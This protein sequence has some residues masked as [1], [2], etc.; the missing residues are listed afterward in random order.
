MLEEVKKAFYIAKKDLR[1]YYFK[2][3]TISWGIVFPFVF[4]FA[5]LIRSTNKAWI[6]PGLLALS[7]L[8]SSTSM[9]SASVVFERRIG[10]F[11]RLLLF[12]IS[13]T[14]IAF[15]K[16]LS[17]FFFGVLSSILTVLAIFLF[18]GSLPSNPFFLFLTLI[19][20]AFQFSSLGVFLSFIAKDPPQ[21]MVFVNIVRFLMMFMCGIFVPLSSLPTFI[22]P[23]SLA[24]P[25][26]YSVEAIRF[27]MTG[28][29]E[30]IPPY[31]SF[32]I[33]LLSFPLFLYTTTFLI[34][35]SLE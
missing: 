2:P 12:P 29:Y 5:F 18:L 25:L 3:P 31:I 21:S 6:S 13:Y 1:Q 26:T 14:G 30:V 24:L 4:A 9:S 10:S 28:S 35:R 11:E 20:V 27:G 32:A 17:S 8:F 15:G 23:F 16:A 34:K 19:A 7:I 22:L 33:I